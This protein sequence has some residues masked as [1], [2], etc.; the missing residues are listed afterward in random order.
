MEKLDKTVVREILITIQ[1]EEVI[2]F[3]LLSILKERNPD[4]NE[5][6]LYMTLKSLSEQGCINNYIAAED[7]NCKVKLKY[8]LSEKGKKVLNSI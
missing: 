1:S 6:I 4:F 8:K 7:D 3:Q 2:D 5:T